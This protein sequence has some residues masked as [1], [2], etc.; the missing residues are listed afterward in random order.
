MVMRRNAKTSP[1]STPS[2]KTRTCSQWSQLGPSMLQGV[3]RK[4][5]SNRFPK[6]Q[7]HQQLFM[8]MFHHFSRISAQFF[9]ENAHLSYI[10]AEGGSQPPAFAGVSLATT[11]RTPFLGQHYYGNEKHGKQFDWVQDRP[12]G[13]NCISCIDMS[14]SRI[15]ILKLRGMAAQEISCSFT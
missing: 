6:K 10:S 8:L 15:S 4:R 14:C 7:Q 1:C 13:M 12:P 11:R 3:N 2:G 5:Y 9:S